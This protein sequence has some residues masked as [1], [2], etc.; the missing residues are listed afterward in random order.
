MGQVRSVPGL[1]EQTEKCIDVEVPY[2]RR[3]F[4]YCSLQETHFKSNLSCRIL[5]ALDAAIYF[6]FIIN[7][8]YI[9][10]A[11]DYTYR[12][13]GSSEFVNL[14]FDSSHL[15]LCCFHLGRRNLL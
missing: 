7:V 9:V 1:I 4:S 2:L 6:Q 13:A 15:L 11:C 5:R 10:V 12:F 3:N 8:S 14:T